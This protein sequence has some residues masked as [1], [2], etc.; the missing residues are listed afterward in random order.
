MT[1]FSAVVCTVARP[2][3]LRR[4]LGALG[5]CDPPP[6]EVLVVD[7]DESQSA[8]AVVDEF[9]GVRHVPSPR[10]LTKQRNRGIAESTG[11]VV[12]FFDD[13]ARPAPDVFAHVARAYVDPDVVGATG[14]VM[15]PGDHLRGGR[16]SFVRRLL[17]G[18]GPPGTFTA[19]GYPRRFPPIEGEFDVCFMQGCFLTVR[20]EP[21]AVLGFDEQLPGYGLAEDEDFSYRLSR[22][23]RIRYVGDAVVEHDNT[24]FSTRDQRAFGRQLVVNR[25]HLFRKN[26]PQTRW[27]RLQ[28]RW[29]LLVLLG[30]R[31]LNRDREGARGLLDGMA[32]VRRCD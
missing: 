24:G 27:A 13:D 32:E 12:A 2:D 15:E 28:F 9:P 23:G 1:A 30:H 7:G 25:T 4:C 10:G 31:L 21:A 19:G 8:R 17:T 20:R 16:G 3:D 5:A 11:D 26:F 29:A 18:F 22:L 14:R 6:L